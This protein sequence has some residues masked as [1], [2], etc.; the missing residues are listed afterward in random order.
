V[1]LLY[2]CRI[3]PNGKKLRKLHTHLYG[4]SWCIDSELSFFPR[5]RFN[6]DSLAMF[7]TGY[8]SLAYYQFYISGDTLKLKNY[9]GE[10]IN[11]RLDF[12]NEKKLEIELLSLENRK[13]SYTNCSP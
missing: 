12:L 2:S 4:V 7:S 11:M 8:D 9:L 1:I 13:I 5:I 6:E 10:R 3:L